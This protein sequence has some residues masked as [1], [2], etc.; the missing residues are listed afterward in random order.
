MFNAVQ[1]AGGLGASDTHYYM[2]NVAPEVL[3]RWWEC[4]V[5]IREQDPPTY[6]MILGSLVG[7]P[8]LDE[9]ER[10]A[11][12]S[13]TRRQE[14]VPSPVNPRCRS[15]IDGFMIPQNAVAEAKFCS[16]HLYRDA[17]FARNYPQVAMQMHCTN[18]DYGLIIVGQGTAT[19]FEIECVRDKVGYEP[20][21][22][23]RA[24][25]M[26][27]SMDTMTPPVAIDTPVMV[28]PERWRTI[29]LATDTPNWREDLIENLAVY[30]DTRP[31]ADANE[32]A[33]KAAKALIPDDVGKV[34]AFNF[35]ITRNRKGSLVITRRKS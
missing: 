12:V 33:G 18:A 31:L 1:R 2:N 7:D 24:A 32:Q 23:E 17:I 9:Y 22:L 19:P 3:L 15:T 16:A 25:A 8:I 13:I 29:D 27:E 4:K 10:L 11:A 35:T 28:P 26:L 5:G 20:L 30:E 34:L 21:M 6:P 14:V